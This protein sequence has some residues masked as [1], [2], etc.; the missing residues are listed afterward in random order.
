MS[1]P[2]NV[3]KELAM[4]EHLRHGARKVKHAYEELAETDPVPRHRDLFAMM[5]R[6]TSN[7]ADGLYAAI[8]RP[9]NGDE[10]Y[11]RVSNQSDCHNRFCPPSAR[12]L[13]GKQRGLVNALIDR[14]Y[15]SNP[16]I[17]MRM[18]TGT[19]RNQPMAE[20]A[21]MFS[22]IKRAHDNLM[23]HPRVQR[24][25]L[26]NWTQYECP[27][28]RNA[29]GELEAGWHFHTMLATDETSLRLDWSEWRALLRAAA[30]V[31]YDPMV[32]IDTISERPDESPHEAALHASGEVCK[33]ICSPRAL[34]RKPKPKDLFDDPDTMEWE[35]IP[36]ALRYLTLTVRKKRLHR[37]AGIWAEAMTQHR[38]GHENLCEFGGEAAAS[39]VPL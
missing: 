31:D 1:R 29:N 4:W 13:A 23:A 34:Q 5:A 10:P 39:S 27:P 7:C 32:W 8:I 14:I 21:D 18:L 3:V 11:V 26:G 24:A 36:E 12:K 38:R 17:R 22:R 19:L 37:Y 28:R 15:A 2:R 33:Y 30:G 35:V 16:S 25:H 20:C 6:R 9:A